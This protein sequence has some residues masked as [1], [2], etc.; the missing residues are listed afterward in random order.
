[1]RE[2]VRERLDL[3]L[4]SLADDGDE[5]WFVSRFN[6]RMYDAWV[7]TANRYGDEEGWFWD[8]HLVV[9][10][11]CGR[12]RTTSKGQKQVLVTECAFPPECSW[13][14]WLLR[15]ALVKAS[16]VPHV[17]QNWKRAKSYL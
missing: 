6:A 16:L 5:N 13:L 8:G 14:T 11:P 9:S 4:L 7:V 10:D 1:M 12:L 15:N 3:I 17:L 2:R